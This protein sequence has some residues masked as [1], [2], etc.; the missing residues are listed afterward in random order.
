M[1]RLRAAPFKQAPDPSWQTNG[2]V[3]AIVYSGTTV[4]IGGEFT[5]VRPPGGGAPVARNHLAAI[6]SCL[7][8][9]VAVHIV[10]AHGY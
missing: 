9:E 4:Y 8:P 10:D 3:R 2:R 6:D 7:W 5:E 1:S